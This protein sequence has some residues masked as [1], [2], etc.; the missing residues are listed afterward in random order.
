MNSNHG[1]N[2]RGLAEEKDRNM[3]GRGRQRERERER[4]SSMVYL[5]S[6]VDLNGG[7]LLAA[8]AHGLQG[9]VVI[10]HLKLATLEVLGL[11]QGDL[12]VTVVLWL[13]RGRER[14]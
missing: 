12:A 7:H 6:R 4:R 14:E 10:A 3:I 1:R 8:P 5:R 9:R 2:P 11:V 13:E